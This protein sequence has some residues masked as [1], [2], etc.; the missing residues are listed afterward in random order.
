[1]NSFKAALCRMSGACIGNQSG[2]G[3][4]RRTYRLQWSTVLNLEQ[5]QFNELSQEVL[6]PVQRQFKNYLD[7]QTEDIY[8]DLLNSILNK[9]NEN[10]CFLLDPEAKADES[11]SPFP[12]W[13]WTWLQKELALK[14]VQSWKHVKELTSLCVEENEFFDKRTSELDAALACSFFGP[15]KDRFLAITGHPGNGIS[16]AFAHCLNRMRMQ[17][18]FKGSE[19]L[20]LIRFSEFANS[21]FLT[22]LHSFLANC[23]HQISW[24]YNFPSVKLHTITNLDDSIEYFLDLLHVIENGPY[25]PLVL[26]FDSLD[27]IFTEEEVEIFSNLILKHQYPCSS[28]KILFL[29]S[30]SEYTGIGVNYHSLDLIRFREV[31]AVASALLKQSGRILTLEQWLCLLEALEHRAKPEVDH[32]LVELRPSSAKERFWSTENEDSESNGTSASADAWE[33]LNVKDSIP[34]GN[35]PLT[36]LDIRS[37]IEICC[38][39]WHSY[40]LTNKLWLPP[41]TS[42]NVTEECFNY[43]CRQLEKCYGVQ[44]VAHTLIF[45]SLSSAGIT[46]VELE[47]ALSCQNIVLNEVYARNDPVTRTTRMNDK[48]MGTGKRKA[49]LSLL[50]SLPPIIRVPGLIWARLY[51]H[52]KKVLRKSYSDGKILLQWRHTIYREAVLNRYNSY[53]LELLQD[54][55]ATVIGAEKPIQKT[56]LLSNE[57]RKEVESVRSSGKRLSSSCPGELLVIHADRGVTHAPFVHAHSSSPKSSVAN[58]PHRLKTLPYH[59]LKAQNYQELIDRCLLNVEFLA[60]SCALLTTTVS[61]FFRNYHI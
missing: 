37:C 19:P 9:H 24:M 5:E 56:C 29:V 27:K 35:D 22:Q 59:L 18:R 61:F 8:G 48:S 43:L 45:L 38:T 57:Y 17:L 4:T 39:Q 55:L 53:C 25:P 42:K 30:F 47:D 49:S 12:P 21:G 46:E 6:S 40:D 1:M 58:C 26:A 52:L 13:S 41:P 14:A 2:V 34:T 28:P 33:L 11:L 7:S 20:F 51:F 36:L 15:T 10:N 60:T 3:L 44:L 32:D 31:A 54:E 23:I 16:T 50:A